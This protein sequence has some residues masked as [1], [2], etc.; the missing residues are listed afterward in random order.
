MKKNL[1]I[2]R[3]KKM[4]NS[5]DAAEQIVRISLEGAEVALKLTGNAAKEIALFLVAA[6]KGSGKNLKL[7]GKARMTSMLKSGKPLEIFSIK[8]SDLRQFTQSAK[9]YGIVYCVLRNTKNSPDGLCDVM[10]KADDAPKISRIIER[11]DFA[12]VDKATIEREIVTERAERSEDIEFD[13]DTVPDAPDTDYADRLVADLLGISETEKE[14]TDARPLSDGGTPP[15]H[16]SGHTSESR[17]KPAEPT[18]SKRSVKDEIRKITAAKKVKET[19][20]PRRDEP[21]ADKPKNAPA[22]NTHKQPPRGKSKKSKS[23]GRG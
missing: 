2:R 5:G 9:Q 11:F 4:L 22:A 19:D 23:K 18:L 16:P 15:L 14:L 6:L 12:T 1:M 17:K 21:L 13:F 8:D 7:K 20:A 3:Q 10:V